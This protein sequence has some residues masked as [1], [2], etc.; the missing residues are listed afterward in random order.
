MHKAGEEEFENDAKRVTSM[1]CSIRSQLNNKYALIHYASIILGI[2]GIEN[3]PG[4]MLE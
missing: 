1:Q 4:I 2:I 3:H